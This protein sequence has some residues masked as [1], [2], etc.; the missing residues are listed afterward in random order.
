[1]KISHQYKLSFFILIFI[2]LLYSGMSRAD[3]L[4]GGEIQFH[5]F[6][7]DEAPKWMWQIGSSEQ[8]WAVDTADAR[9]EN[10]QLIFDLHDKG[11][12]PFLEGHLLEVAE[13][14]GPGFTPFVSFSSNSQP[15]TVTDGNSTTAQHFRASV[16]V[17][18]PENG[19]VTGQLYFTLNQGIAVSTGI[20]DDGVSVPAGMSLLSGQSVT[21]VRSDSLPQELKNRLSS[22]LLMNQKF[23]GGMSAVDNGQVISQGVLSDGRVT[24]FAAAYASSVSDFELHLPAEGTPAQW[25]AKLN[26]TVTVQ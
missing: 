14:G 10:G 6:V 1:M 18:N 19:Q 12:L 25:Q 4:D 15:F 7:T 22:L 13:R 17:S 9:T 24:N 26:V 8:S 2:I 5:G 16:P 11:S 20:Q 21:N 23:G 3:I